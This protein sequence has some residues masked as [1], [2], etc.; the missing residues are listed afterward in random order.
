METKP[1]PRTSPARI[2]GFRPQDPRLH[3][4][5]AATG[6][7]RHPRPGAP[8]A[9]CRTSTTWCSWARRCR[10]TRWRA[11]ARSAHRSR[12]RHPLREEADRARRSRHHRRHELRRAVGERE[13]GAGRGATALGTS[14]TTG[15][16]GMTPEERGSSKTWSTSACPRATA[17]T[18]TILRKRRRDRGGDRQGAKPG[19]GGMLLGQKV[20]PRVARCAP[21]RR[22]STSARPA[23]TP[24]GPAPT[25]WPSRSRSCARSPTGRSRST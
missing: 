5:A 14:T 12:A 3:P 13:G 8:S 7:L 25:T 10:A 21:A 9:S 17:S 20:N 18:R 11:T 16:G 24:T 4:R 15:D 22:A 2:R 23:A 19:G 1:V 6:H